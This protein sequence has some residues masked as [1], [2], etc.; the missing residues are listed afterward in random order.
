MGYQ[1]AMSLFVDHLNDTQKSA[2]LDA[3]L[4]IHQSLRTDAQLSQQPPGTA[5]EQVSSGEVE[6]TLL[7]RRLRFRS[8][9]D[10]AGAIQGRFRRLQLLLRDSEERAVALLAFRARQRAAVF[11]NAPLD[12]EK[13]LVL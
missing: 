1:M 8:A 12:G 5:S 3:R 7:L 4:H 9:A 6:T 10:C 13:E 2:Q 11:G